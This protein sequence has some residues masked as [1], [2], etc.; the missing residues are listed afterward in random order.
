MV[1]DCAATLS[2]VQ[3]DALD[4]ALSRADVSGTGEP[5]A[6]AVGL[7]LRSVLIGLAERAPVLLAIDDVGWIDVSSAAALAFVARRLDEQAVGFLATA[8]TPAEELDPLALERSSGRSNAPHLRSAR[9]PEKNSS[10][11]SPTGSRLG[12]VPRRVAS[13]RRGLGR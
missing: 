12:F 4:R 2:D 8:R 1:G 5:D 9:S 10:S 6:K 13:D 7:A 3:R 11:W